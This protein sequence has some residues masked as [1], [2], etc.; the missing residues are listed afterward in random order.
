MLN[1]SLGKTTK[2][3]Q[4]GWAKL[5]YA[6]KEKNNVVKNIPFKIIVLNFLMNN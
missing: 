5:F 4:V 3:S 6:G 2:I 1:Q